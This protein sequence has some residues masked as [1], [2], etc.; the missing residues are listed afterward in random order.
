VAVTHILGQGR[1]E[2][3][4]WTAPARI[5]SGVLSYGAADPGQERFEF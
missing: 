4:P 5:V 3:H 1:S 2:P